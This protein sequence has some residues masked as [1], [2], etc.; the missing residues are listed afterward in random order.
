MAWQAIW[1]NAHTPLTPPLKETFSME[2]EAPSTCKARLVS[3][4]QRMI[5]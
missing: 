4:P 5:R 3:E 1:V 2:R